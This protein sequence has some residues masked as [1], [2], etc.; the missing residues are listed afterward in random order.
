VQDEDEAEEE[1][2]VVEGIYG[3][4]RGVWEEEGEKAESV[5]KTFVH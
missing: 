2:L 3:S 5:I 1:G 4:R